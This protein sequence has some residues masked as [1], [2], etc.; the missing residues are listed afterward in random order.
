MWPAA[1]TKRTFHEFTVDVSDLN[2]GS[3]LLAVEVHQAN[4]TSSD[5]SFDLELQGGTFNSGSGNIYYTLDGSDPRLEGGGISPTAI[6]YNGNAFQLPQT[7]IIKSRVKNG[8]EWSPLN[9]AEFQIDTPAAAGSLAITEINYN[10]YDALTQFGDA[11][12]DNDEFEFVELTNI[13][14]ER[15]DLTDV[16]F[17]SASN[18]GSVE[19]IEFRFATQAIDPG[20]RIVVVRNRTA[21]AS[22]YGNSV[23]IA[24][25]QGVAG[26][27]GV[28]DGGLSNGG[29]L[30]TL[31]DAQGGIIQQFQYDDS[32]K[33]PGLR[34][35]Q[36]VDSGD[37]RPHS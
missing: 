9:T 16:Q 24:E 13:S 29:E 26:G 11:N 17:V 6:N 15:I 22:R 28:Y 37:C 33:W 3:N 25:R 21:F 30:L 10:P 18:Q 7:T 1:E 35:R 32:G 27:T 2:Q 12:L 8:S 14:N 34:R 4:A 5:I 19:G 23:N 31:Q 20:E 36:W